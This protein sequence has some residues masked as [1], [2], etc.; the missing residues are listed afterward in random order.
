MDFEKLYIN[1]EWVVPFT[2]DF[3]EVID[4]ADESIIGRVPRC[5]R[6]DADLAV[7]SAKDA[8]E[9]WQDTSLAKRVNLVERL[10]EEMSKR[11]DEFADMIVRELGRASD[12][13]LKYHTLPYIED[14]RNFIKIAK[15]YKLEEDFGD[16]IIRKEPVGVV[17]AL[18]PWNYPLG[19]ITSKIIPALLAGCTIVLKPSQ[20]TPMVAYILAEAIHAAGFPKG[21]FNLL[22]GAGSEVGNILAEH[23][24]VNMI[25]FTGSTKSGREVAQKSMGTVKRITLE[26][27]GKS[28]AIILRGISDIEKPLK[29]VLNSVYNNTGQTCSAYTRL[30]VHEDEKEMIEKAVVQMTKAYK[31]GDPKASPMNIGPLV[32]ENQ[33][34]KVKAYIEKGLEE[35]ARLIYGSLPEKK[36][37]GFYIGPTVFTDVKNNMTI[38][39][40]EIFGPVLSIISYR[41]AEEAVK[42][43]NDTIYGLAA[44]VFGPQEEAIEI[45]N[46]LKAGNVTVNAGRGSYDAPFGGYKQSGLGREGGVYGL[47]EFLEIKAVFV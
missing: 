14:T 31:F 19:Q 17:G 37:L 44:A 27:G 28:P 12:F 5:G 9:L 34:K 8:F 23:P 1:G 41:D 25:T 38:A 4:P 16:Y 32:S 26:L 22:T 3:I 11:K 10:C 46:R 6:E 2:K 29:R 39:R 43:A 21:V 24:D 7:K 33:Y 47:E 18:T 40:E 36:S 20:Q 35:G 15:A 42:I 30:I 45:A 13:A